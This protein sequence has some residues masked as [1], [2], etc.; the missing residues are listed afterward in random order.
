MRPA[1]GKSSSRVLDFAQPSKHNTRMTPQQRQALKNRWPRG[2]RHDRTAITRWFLIAADVLKQ[3]P[4][5]KYFQ[6]AT[7]SIQFRNPYKRIDYVMATGPIAKRIVE[8]RFLFQGAF[9]LTV[10]DPQKF[11]LSDHLP[12]MAVFDSEP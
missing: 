4:S 8:S 12:Q 5:G 6:G 9:R 11:A 1:P 7:G 10:A 2:I 3:C